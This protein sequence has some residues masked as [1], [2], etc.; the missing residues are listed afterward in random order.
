MGDLGTICENETNTFVRATHITKHPASKQL[1]IG[2]ICSVMENRPTASRPENPEAAYPEDNFLRQTITTQGC[3]TSPFKQRGTP[4]QRVA[5]CARG[6]FLVNHNRVA[7][8]VHWETCGNK[9]WVA[10]SKSSC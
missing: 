9:V 6:H 10:K 2:A 3:R 8:D 7:S 1:P 5:A 4:S